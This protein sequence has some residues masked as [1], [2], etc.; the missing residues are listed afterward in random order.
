MAK[1][2]PQKYE[3][4][5]LCLHP[6]F[7]VDL[8]LKDTW[9]GWAVTFTNRKWENHHPEKKKKVWKS[10]VFQLEQRNISNWKWGDV[11]TQIMKNVRHFLMTYRHLSQIEIIEDHFKI[12]NHQIRCSARVLD[13]WRL[14]SYFK[15]PLLKCK[16][17][18]VLTNMA[19]QPSCLKLWEQ[20][21][22]CLVSTVHWKTKRLDKVNSILRDLAAWHRSKP[23]KKTMLKYLYIYI[24][25]VYIY[26]V[27]CCLVD[28]DFFAILIV[29]KPYVYIYIGWFHHH[30]KAKG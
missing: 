19:P 17:V 5:R 7:E 3:H 27:K 14:Q 13:S 30:Y 1:K 2:N 24:Y 28:R 22:R 10:R 26:Y 18:L 16:Q 23:W 9:N 11:S 29:D 8:A 4:R 12:K 25:G 15:L 6:F 20:Q 21:P